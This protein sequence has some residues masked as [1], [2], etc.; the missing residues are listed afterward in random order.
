MRNRIAKVAAGVITLGCSQMPEAAR[1]Y[2]HCSRGVNVSLQHATRKHRSRLRIT[3]QHGLQSV[4]DVKVATAAKSA[5]HLAML[6]RS[7][8]LLALLCR[9]SARDDLSADANQAGQ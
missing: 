5:L 3:A 1:L 7:S 9:S 8:P 4:M 2:Q 6:R